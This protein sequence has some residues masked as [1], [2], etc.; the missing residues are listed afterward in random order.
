MSNVGTWRQ[1]LHWGPIVALS[2]IF[3]ISI[4]TINCTLMWWPV[5]SFGGAVN[6]II[7]LTWIT[8]TLYNYFQAAWKGPGFVPLGW[9]PN[10]PEARKCLQ[11][12]EACAGFKSP[13]SH[14]CRKCDRCVMKMDHHCPWINTCCGHFNHANFVWFLLFAPCGCVHA[15]FILIP[16]IYRALN[17]HY[18]YFYHQDEP[19]VQLDIFEFILTMFGIGLAIGVVIAVGMLF[20]LQMKSIL[21]NETGIESWIID[22]AEDRLREPEEG[23]FVYPYNLGYRRNFK[24]V[25][26]WTGKPLSDGFTWNIVNGCDQYTLTI[27]QIK[28]KGEKR[29]R[30]VQYVIMEG[31]SG[32]LFPF[33][34]G[35]KV[36][37]CIPCTD[38]P[39]ISVKPGNKV[40]VTRWKRHWL[41]GTRLLTA[42]EKLVGTSKPRARGWFPRRCAKEVIDDNMNDKKAS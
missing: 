20:Y 27:E 42:E 1:L 22:K 19:L 2:V 32:Y 23:D 24:E 30:T 16:S 18:Y 36:S 7:F 39:R 17:F 28:Q 14:H 4:A 31:Y 33:T 6:F 25:F 35:L 29:E 13:R 21:K 40:W 9:M 3:Y 8:L 5:T 26:T 15:V 11:F 34:K 38:E 37:C 12:C 41:Y 10:K